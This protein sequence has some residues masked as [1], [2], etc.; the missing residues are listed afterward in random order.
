MK[1]DTAA[2]AG[3]VPAN[4]QFAVLWPLED[5]R[6]D[7]V[8]QFQSW[9]REQ[10][11]P[12][13]RFQVV[14]I[15]SGD[16][17]A[18]ERRVAAELAPHDVFVRGGGLHLVELWRRAATHAQAPWL[19]ITEAH[20]RA[21][22]DCLTAAAEQP[23]SSWTTRPGVGKW[24]RGGPDRTP[25]TRSPPKSCGPARVVRAGGGHL[26]LGGHGQSCGESL[27]DPMTN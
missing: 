16:D 5:T 20:C 23:N 13:E 2:S 19:V 3:R 27:G 10:T 25:A 9:T 6:E 7:P 4:L 17:L 18:A 1:R 24:G 8:A 14:A 22:P 15:A 26:E 21:A 11:L 12:R